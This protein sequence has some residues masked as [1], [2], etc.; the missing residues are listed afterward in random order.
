M[1]FQTIIMQ[2]SKKTYWLVVYAFVTCLLSTHTCAETIRLAVATNFA[3]A[4]NQ[5]AWCFEQETGHQ[6]RIS[7]G[8]S[9]KLYSQIT[10][11]A[12]YD[13]FL[14]ADAD[15]PTRLINNR[16]ASRE[17]SL[18]YAI[19]KLVLWSPKRVVNK[20]NA[21]RLLTNAQLTH[22]A[23]A[24]AK[25]APYGVAAIETLKTMGVYTTVKPKLVQ[26]ENIGQAYQYTASGNAAIGMIAYSQ[27]LKPGHQKID[28][29]FWVIPESMHAPIR[30]NAVLLNHA[31]NNAAA[32]IFMRYL[33][34]EKAKTI[35]RS[36]GYTLPNP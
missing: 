5:I 32:K 22:I 10:H 15:K 18:T 1:L 9:G 4:M 29:D 11:G 25:L 34:S 19:G 13:V 7:Y 26:G 36:F 14:S 35:I 27:I 2:V 16:F 30:Q 20:A 33:G 23:I 6:T 21:S 17:H 31:K 8:S 3:D 28:T 24:N 12:P